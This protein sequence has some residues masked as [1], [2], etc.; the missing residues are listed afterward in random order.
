MYERKTGSKTRNCRDAK[1]NDPEVAKFINYLM[2][3]GQKTV[4]ERIVYDCFDI[5]KENQTRATS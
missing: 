5:L 2:K 4:A 1:Y 3:D